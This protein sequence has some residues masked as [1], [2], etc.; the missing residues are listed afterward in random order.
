MTKFVTTLCCAFAI[1]GGA[2]V[3]A[4]PSEGKDF[5]RIEPAIATNDPGAIVV[6]EFFSYQCP[7][8]YVFAKPFKQWVATLPADVKVERVAVS[9][10]H[11]SWIPAAQSF[12][13]LTAIK[14]LNTVD[15]ALFDAIHQQRLAMNSQ[16]Q[17]SQWLGEQG[18][19]TNKFDK[20]YEAF[21]VK[22]Q[23]KQAEKSASQ[24]KIPSIPSIAINGKYLVSISDDGDFSDQLAVIEELVAM[25]RAL[26]TRQ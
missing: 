16:N 14:E 6:T 1:L 18:V 21:G 4:A 12:Y 8:C 7:H 17:I 3:Y 11:S 26:Q 19:D 23:L 15:Q 24:H 25:E 13:A 2:A 22:T 9:I 5:K 20:A 10:G